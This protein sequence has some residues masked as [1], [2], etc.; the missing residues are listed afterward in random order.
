MT[1]DTRRL[2]MMTEWQKNRKEERI[3]KRASAAECH[4]AAV[5]TLPG[6]VNWGKISRFN[7]DICITEK[8]DGTNA[9][10]GVT[11]DHRVYAQSRTR[12]IS[13]WDD[14]YGF[15]AWVEKNK[16][17]LVKLGPG[18]HFGEWMG[19]GIN[20]SYQIVERRF[21]LFNVER[22]A[23]NEDGQK[24]IEEIHGTDH[25]PVYVV[26]TIYEGPWF[27]PEHGTF[28]PTAAIDALRDHGSIAIPGYMRPEGLCIYH[29]ASRQI[30]KITLEGDAEHKGGKRDKDG[31]IITLELGGF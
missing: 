10:I 27:D 22:W 17:S 14:N 26:P 4:A 8:I 6:F 11:E 9:A 31:N 30:F 19:V 2:S 25:V 29:K 5:A 21:Y 15:A 16:E 23:K 13:P 7:R 24:I 28:I 3:Q 18:L 20:R 1:D 12:V